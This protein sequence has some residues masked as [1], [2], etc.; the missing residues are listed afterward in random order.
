MQELKLYDPQGRP[1]NWTELAH[2]G[3]YAVFPSNT[4][5]D[6]ACRPDGSFFSRA[7]ES[8]CLV[9]DHCNEAESY[10]QA[11]VEEIPRLRCD[12]FDHT[13]KP[14]PPMLPDR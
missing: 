2:P 12:I 4:H 11:K 1:R 5:T 14:M 10:W 13:G 7:E 8:T 9:F 6:I 3:Q